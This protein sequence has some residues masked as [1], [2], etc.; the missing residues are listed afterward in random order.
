[1]VRPPF[2]ALRA[3]LLL[4]ATSLAGPAL[5]AGLTAAQAAQ[6]YQRNCAACHGEKG[7]GE[8][9]AKASLAKEPRNFTTDEARRDLPR[10]YMVAIVR[11]G[12]HDAPM[13]GRKSR[14][15]EAQMEAIV[16][17]IRTAFMPPEA[18]ST[19]ARGRE[20]YAARCAACHGPRGAGGSQHGTMTVPGLSRVRA[21]DGLTRA[22][23]IAAIA[24]EKHGSLR[25]GFATQLSDADREA[26]VDYIRSTFVEQ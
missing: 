12:K 25:G 21:R 19:R 11:D 18:G 23:M 4:L 22:D 3:F 20:I 24:S 2:P 17:F 5:G 1:M 6:L 14:L 15:T 7:D 9:R 13:V 26:V 10:E 16:D 8:S